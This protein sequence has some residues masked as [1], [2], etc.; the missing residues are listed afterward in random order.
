MR[1]GYF[2]LRGP[3][4]G[5]PVTLLHLEPVTGRRHQ[6]RVHCLAIGHPLVG[7]CA[8]ADDWHSYRLFLHARR[9]ILD[10]LPHTHQCVDAVS[11]CL[12][13]DEA[14]RDTSMR[15]DYRS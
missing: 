15:A 12:D 14:I 11:E 4:E 10:P 3:H 2:S 7:D 6:L 5:K 1:R 8:Y 9:L 13:F